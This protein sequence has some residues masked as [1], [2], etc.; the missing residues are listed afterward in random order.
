MLELLRTFPLAL[1]LKLGGTLPNGK[2]TLA[3]FS[4]S[5]DFIELIGVGWFA[6]VPEGAIG[7]DFI[8]T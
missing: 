2:T 5:S 1:A 3:S 8:R 4:R 7:S 6:C